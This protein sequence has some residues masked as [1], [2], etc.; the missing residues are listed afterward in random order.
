M[1]NQEMRK[2]QKYEVKIPEV[3]YAVWTIEAEDEAI[4]IALQGEGDELELVY[5]H[6]DSDINKWNVKKLKD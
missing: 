2:K 5:S 6:T 1:G 4:E 3:H